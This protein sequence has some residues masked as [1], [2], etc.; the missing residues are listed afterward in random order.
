M[1]MPLYFILI[2]ISLLSVSCG[3]GTTVSKSKNSVSIKMDFESSSKGRDSDGGFMVGSEYI[4]GVKISYG[5]EGSEYQELDVT[6]AARDSSE[7]IIPDLLA[8]E[9]YTF[10]ISAEGEDE[11]IVCSGSTEVEIVPNDTTEAELECRFSGVQSLEL[12]V[13]NLIKT[14]FQENAS[15]EKL[16]DYVA[17]D[18]GVMNGMNREQFITSLTDDADE[19]LFDDNI[20]PVN[21]VISETGLTGKT[22]DIEDNVYDIKIIYSD[23]SYEYVSAG[24]AEEDGEWKIKGNGLAHD[25]EIRHAAARYNSSMQEMDG[26]MITGVDVRMSAVSE[27]DTVTDFT[28]S[29]NGIADTGFTKFSGGSFGLTSPNLYSEMNNMSILLPSWKMAYEI[30][31]VQGSGMGVDTVLTAEYSD[32]TEEQYTVRGGGLE[33]EQ[34]VYNFPFVWMEASG[35]ENYNFNIALPSVFAVSGVKMTIDASWDGGSYHTE[36][37]LSL[38]AP[39]FTI[40][41]LNDILANNPTSFII[42]VTAVDGDMREFTSYYT[43]DDLE[44]QAECGLNGYIPFEGTFKGIGNGGFIAYPEILL[45]FDTNKFNTSIYTTAGAVSGQSLFSVNTVYSFGRHSAD[46]SNNFFNI[47]MMRQG[48]NLY[49]S[50][51]TYSGY[52]SYVEMQNISMFLKGTDGSAYIIS[53]LDGITPENPGII[54]VL[55]LSSDM[56]QV[57]WMKDYHLEFIYPRSMLGGAVIVNNAGTDELI[58]VLRSDEYINTIMRLNTASGSVAESRNLYLPDSG[59]SNMLFAPRILYI[60]QVGKFVLVGNLQEPESGSYRNRI[61][62]ITLNSDF[63]FHSSAFT[64]PLTAFPQINS[65]ASDSSGNIYVESSFSGVEKLFRFNAAADTG[66]QTYSI[67]SVS[68]QNLS[69]DAASFPDEPSVSGSVA[70]S[71]DKAYVLY[72]ISEYKSV[73]NT[74]KVS[75]VLLKL[76]DDFTMESAVV[77]PSVSYIQVMIEGANGSVVLMGKTVIDVMPDMTVGG[78]SL[79]SAGSKVTMAQGSVSLDTSF[80]SPSSFYTSEAAPIVT[81]HPATDAV[82]SA[83]VANLYNLVA[84]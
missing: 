24:F 78:R 63:T 14:S 45:G 28:L 19:Y 15:Y 12:A 79:T 44:D 32:S 51:L 17:S 65:I 42:G 57:H 11:T 68:V 18:F 47:N 83:V 62:L 55:K 3:G 69:F 49:A 67:T 8:G 27:S 56:D 4:S 10:N 36:S 6:S 41:G 40:S 59:S 72:R 1:K 2:L 13:L 5:T 34:T 77:L 30:V 80:Y 84:D 35:S 76:D 25:M 7:V 53:S 58:L 46:G 70:V 48:E 39:S 21:V 43:F 20:K 61:C 29:G 50:S 75:N 71:Q 81:A 33:I 66:A 74:Y 38:A 82:L 54:T 26:L 16:S 22:S 31:P 60:P 23:G 64:E 37:K 52:E 73:M 9:T